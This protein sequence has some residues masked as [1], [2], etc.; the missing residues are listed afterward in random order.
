MFKKFL[1]LWTLFLPAFSCAAS[2]SAE[3]PVGIKQVEYRDSTRQG[4]PM[5]MNI[6]YPCIVPKKDKDIFVVPFTT[7]F[8]LYRNAEV[9][10]HGKPYP[11]ILLSH[12]RSGD[13][14]NLAWLAAYL[15]GHGY[16]VA[17]MDHYFANS[18]FLSYEYVAGKIWERPLDVSANI[19]YLLHDK[20]WKKYIDPSYI[21]VAGHSQGGMTALWVAG[22]KVNAD[23]FMKYQQGR[24]NNPLI[25]AYLR[26]KMPVDAKPALKVHDSRVKAVFSMAPGVIKG[27]GFDE[28]GLANVTV[29]TYLIIGAGDTTVP[30]QDNAG[31]AAKHIRNATL[32]VIPGSVAHEIFL[33]ECD[34]EGKA[35]FPEACIDHPTVDRKEIHALIASKALNFFNTYLKPNHS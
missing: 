7:G 10:F 34:E 5:V 20:Y 21:G 29:P 30:L 19:T 17:S 28:A 31:F 33:N 15:A 8:T 24:K 11:L 23:R 12:G 14:F 22:A 4:R 25:P 32:F 35:E 3:T 9:L 27:F 18:Y 26:G 6:Y 1:L 16:I 13:R 2:L